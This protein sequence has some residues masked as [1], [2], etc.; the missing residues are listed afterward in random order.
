MKTI[1]CSSPAARHDASVLQL[2]GAPPASPRFPWRR[3]CL[4]SQNNAKVYIIGYPRGQDLAFS[5]QD[6][7][8]LDHEGPPGGAQQIPGVSRVHYRTPTEPG[9]SGS[10]VFGASGWEVIALHHKGS[11]DGSESCPG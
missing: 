6:N 10:P 8:L 4:P 9:S 2:E 7:E 1:L 5:F 3:P 11:K